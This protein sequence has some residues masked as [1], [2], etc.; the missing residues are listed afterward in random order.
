[1][2]RIILSELVK[3]GRGCC[4]ALARGVCPNPALNY[5]Y[6]GAYAP[7]PDPSGLACSSHRGR[8]RYKMLCEFNGRP[9]TLVGLNTR[10]KN[11]PPTISM[12]NFA[13]C[14]VWRLLTRCRPARKT[15]RVVV[16][17]E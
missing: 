12:K 1:M 10:D 8:V 11:V 7:H 3:M 6:D 16:E 9:D 14:S 13:R 17:I 4:C 15:G 5:L 2:I